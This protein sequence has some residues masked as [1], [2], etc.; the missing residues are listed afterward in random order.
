MFFV[1][2]IKE[3]FMKLTIIIC[4]LSFSFGGIYSFPGDHNSLTCVDNF[5]IKE[6]GGKAVN[7]DNLKNQFYS[8]NDTD[9]KIDSKLPQETQTAIRKQN[10]TNALKTIRER[11]TASQ[12]IKDAVKANIRSRIE[13]SHEGKE[14]HVTKWGDSLSDF[15]QLYGRMRPAYSYYPF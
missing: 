15:I 8:I 11:Y 9:F 7:D 12:L 4:L 2:V 14:V 13:T 5:F 6:E 10:A 1:P 3:K